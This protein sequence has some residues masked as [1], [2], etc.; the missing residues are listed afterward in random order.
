MFDYTCVCNTEI[1][2]NIFLN[3]LVGTV[4]GYLMNNRSAA[5]PFF[6]ILTQQ[7]LRN[8]NY[9]MVYQTI[10]VPEVQFL[11]TNRK[12]K[13]SHETLISP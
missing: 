7:Y 10:L 1:F 8:Q 12:L 9:E 6:N 13:V 11:Q 4:V 2:I 5:A 3:T